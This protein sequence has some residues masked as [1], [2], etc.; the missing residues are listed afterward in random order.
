MATRSTKTPRS[1]R[2]TKKAPAKRRAVR[3]VELEFAPVKTKMNRAQIIQTMVENVEG[4]D[5]KQAKSMLDTLGQIIMASVCPKSVGV[6]TLPGL[7]N[8]KVQNVKAKKIKAIKKGTEVRNPFTG[9]I[10]EHPGRK[11]GIKPATKK[12][13]AIPMRQLKNAVF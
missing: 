11:A 7:L 5:K 3:K 8:I 6:F 1:T 9:E 10:T 4:I 13:R 12:V 2:S